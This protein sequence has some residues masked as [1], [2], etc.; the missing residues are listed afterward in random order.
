M[1]SPLV[2][3]AQQA[4]NL[5]YLDLVNACNNG[6]IRDPSPV[7]REVDAEEPIPLC[8]SDDPTSPIV[9]LLRPQIVDLLAAEN[10]VALSKGQP[11]LWHGIPITD[12]NTQP[13]IS[14]PPS[15]NT[16]SMREMCERWSQTGLFASIIGPKKW[17]DELYAVYRD[18]F[19]VHDYPQAND[20]ED[21]LNFAFETERAACALFGIV[22]YSVNMNM[23]QEYENSAG[24]RSL[25]IWIPTRAKTK[26]QWPGFLDNTVA[27]GIP[28]RISM[29]DALIKECGE[30]AK[31]DEELCRRHLRPVGCVSYLF[32]TDQGWLQPEV[33]YIYDF[34]IPPTTDPTST[35][36]K[37][38]VLDGEVEFFQASI[39]SLTDVISPQSHGPYPP[40]LMHKPQ[41]D[42]ALRAGRV[43]PNCAI[44]LVDLFIRLGYITPDN[45][46]DYLRI[47][48]GLHGGFDYE[49][50]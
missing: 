2:L 21:S 3:P 31:L 38:E 4:Q 49:R 5:S 8:L 30:E 29:L 47:V 26:S 7:P 23:Y 41:I 25:K 11:A 32:R 1:H 20:S 16:H 15:I 40:Q 34:R 35:P 37:P 12:P 13:R 22:T 36:F 14:F 46:P 48:T 33:E 27:G 28:S 9:G 24:K 50:W 18:P 10:D 19:G 44:V 6:R 42:A 43:K 39:S 45:E 17:R